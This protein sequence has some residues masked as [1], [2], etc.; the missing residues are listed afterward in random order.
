[1]ERGRD[2][3]KG[4]SREKETKQT[5]KKEECKDEDH[6]AVSCNSRMSS[7]TLVLCTCLATP[8][9]RKERKG[10]RGKEPE[11]RAANKNKEEHCTHTQ[12]AHAHALHTPNMHTHTPHLGGGAGGG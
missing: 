10:S 5:T 11:K 8:R 1:M 6:K 12:H 9:G 7:A 2:D 4:E 3:G